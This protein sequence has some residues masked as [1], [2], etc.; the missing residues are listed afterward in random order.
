MFFTLI[1]FEMCPIKYCVSIFAINK[2]IHIYK[3]MNNITV[4]L[5]C[6]KIKITKL[7]YFHIPFKREQ[8]YVWI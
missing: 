6:A 8:N 4:A 7:Y 5:N 2:Y 3:S 1:E